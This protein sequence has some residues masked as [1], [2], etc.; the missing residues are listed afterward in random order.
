MFR[1]HSVKQISVSSIATPF[2]AADTTPSAI[3]LAPVER[4]RAGSSSRSSSISSSTSSDNS[5][6]PPEQLIT[7]RPTSAAAL[8]QSTRPTKRPKIAS[9]VSMRNDAKDSSDSD[10]SPSVSSTSSSSSSS[11]SSTSSSSSESS[12]GANPS[13]SKPAA[14][15]RSAPTVPPGQGLK[16]TAK[17][18]QRRRVLKAAREA[19]QLAA[20]R[21][22]AEPDALTSTIAI[23]NPAVTSVV[24]RKSPVVPE[25]ITTRPAAPIAN[26]SIP[27]SSPPKQSPAATKS[28]KALPLDPYYDIYGPKLDMLHLAAGNKNKKKSIQL[29][30]V[31]GSNAETPAKKIYFGNDQA[32]NEHNVESH[33]TDRQQK[34]APFTTQ[35]ASPQITKSSKRANGPAQ[36]TSQ[37][38]TST[39]YR[40]VSPD[41][42]GTPQSGTAAP[43]SVGNASTLPEPKTSTLAPSQRRD[44]PPHIQVTWVDVEEP[45]WQAGLGTIAKGTSI[46]YAGN[47]AMRPSSTADT[48]APS[49]T[50][51]SR[52]TKESSWPSIAEVEHS[53]ASGTLPLVDAQTSKAGQLVAT[54]VSGLNP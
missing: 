34:Q 5:A 35:S 36:E 26:E 8:S 49:A 40:M 32:G 11:S 21:V 29:N 48:M 39:S 47:P 20:T 51:Q 17:R 4:T 41:L 16:R 54:R 52:N 45:G 43:N 6:I 19:A 12:S 3:P 14:A 7:K 33:T 9:D 31:A 2:K 13:E 10:S 15:V 27:N 38:Q 24:S 44:L 50:A 46:N 37:S 22:A 42:S 25:A 1:T 18:N 53:L 30:N 23:K 28:S